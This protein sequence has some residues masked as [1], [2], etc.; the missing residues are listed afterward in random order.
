MG[1]TL[2]GKKVR[3]EV[4]DSGIGGGKTAD[5]FNQ[6]CVMMPW[7]V[8]QIASNHSVLSVSHYAQ[9]IRQEELRK[10]GCMQTT[11]RQRTRGWYSHSWEERC[12]NMK[13]K[14]ILCISSRGT[15]TW[16]T[17]QVIIEYKITDIFK[18]FQGIP[19]HSGVYFLE[20]NG[21]NANVTQT[22]DTLIELKWYS[23]INR[24]KILPLNTFILSKSTPTASTTLKTNTNTHL[25]CLHPAGLFDLV[26]DDGSVLTDR[27]IPSSQTDGVLGK[28]EE[29]ENTG[30]I[31]LKDFTFVCVW[32]CLHG[33]LYVP[34][35][36]SHSS[37]KPRLCAPD[38]ERVSKTSIS[39]WLAHWP[40]PPQSPKH[41]TL[42]VYVHFYTCTPC[43][44]QHT[45]INQPLFTQIPFPSNTLTCTVWPHLHTLL[46]CMTL[47][48]SSQTHMMTSTFFCVVLL[49]LSKSPPCKVR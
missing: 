41:C 37:I 9:G 29:G 40:I 14:W 5:L 36:D 1:E 32:E 46:T 23:G 27:F 49:Y 28:K 13:R 15:A 2:Q 24:N 39:A 43:L 3:R 25:N 30:D 48:S 34:M 44:N 31:E 11:D 10:G 38:Y 12:L 45:H 21:W 42:G 7:V 19:W 18:C 26:V 4:E 22:A 33:R 8:F 6:V 47:P 35:M 20:G 17:S 16:R